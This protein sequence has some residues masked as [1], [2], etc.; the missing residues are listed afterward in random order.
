MRV[1]YHGWIGIWRCWCLWREENQRTW[2]KTLGAG[3]ITNNKLNPNVTWSRKRT[4]A[5]AVGGECSYHCTIPA[6]LNKWKMVLW[7]WWQ[8]SSAS[9]PYGQNLSINWHQ[10]CGRRSGLIVS[11][12]NSGASGPGSILGRGHCVVFLGKTVPL[13]TQVCKWVPSNLMVGVTL[14]WTSIP[15][16]GGEQKY[17]HSLHATETGISSGLMGH[18][19]RM[20]TLPL[21][22]TSYKWLTVQHSTACKCSFKAHLSLPK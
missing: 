11:A 22:D 5:T 14:W 19:A 16:K 21:P 13:S 10:L 9:K 3:T 15:S 4:W 7:D 12:L 18:L 20:Q 8:T 2:R 6:P 1:L 17:S